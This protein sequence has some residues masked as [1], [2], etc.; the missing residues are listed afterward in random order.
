MVRMAKKGVEEGTVLAGG[1]DLGGYLV[2]GPG[3]A[4][5]RILV[6]IGS[7]MLRRP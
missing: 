7:R 2:F 3:P 5:L 4:A 1:M 6:G